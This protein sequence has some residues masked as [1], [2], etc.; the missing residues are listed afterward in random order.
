V[1]SAAPSR[2]DRRAMHHRMRLPC[3]MG[4]HVVWDITSNGTERVLAGNRRRK[5]TRQHCGLS[6]QAWL[7]L[8]R[9]ELP[10]H[11]YKKVLTKLDSLI[12]IMTRHGMARPV[13]PLVWVV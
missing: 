11:V 7:A 10:L 12:S 9:H 6:S 1:L 3:R 5:R 4:C 8:L 13:A 2:F